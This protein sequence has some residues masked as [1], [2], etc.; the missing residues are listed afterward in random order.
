MKKITAVIL[1]LCMLLTSAVSVSAEINDKYS[2]EVQAKIELVERAKREQSNKI[3]RISVISE[4]QICK[5]AAEFAM[6]ISDLTVKDLEAYGLYTLE[7]EDALLDIAPMSQSADVFMNT[8]TIQYNSNNGTWIITG[9]GY[10]INDNYKNDMHFS[11]GDQQNQGSPDAYGVGFTNINDANYYTFLRGT[12][13]ITDGNGWTLETTSRNDG[14]SSTGFG[15]RLQDVIK[16]DEY[17][18]VS[19]LGKHFASQ[20]IYD[21]NFVN[22]TGNAAS[23][24]IHTWKS[25]QITS[26]TLTGKTDKTAGLSVTLSN[27]AESFTAFSGDK[28]Y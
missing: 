7:T 16:V 3:N 20:G 10:W 22:A 5:M 15:Y 18:S 11:F 24:Y 19:Y 2:S 17:F 8:P 26:L 12:G 14:N 13:Y 21:S 23:Y 1:S 6:G 25:C 27:Y 9:G 4:E 28:R